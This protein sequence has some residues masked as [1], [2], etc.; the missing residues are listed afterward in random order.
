MTKTNNNDLL[1]LELVIRASVIQV[2]TKTNNNDLLDLELVIRASVFK[3][4]T[5]TNN[6]DLLD[7]ELVISA[8][9]FKVMTKTKRIYHVDEV[10][11]GKTRGVNLLVLDRALARSRREVHPEGFPYPHLINVINYLSCLF[12]A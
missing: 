6:Y 12:L 11:I 7:L 9:V 3:V 1:D 8:S 2:M 5:K 10:R 4:M